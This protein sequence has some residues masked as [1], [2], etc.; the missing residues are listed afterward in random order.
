V[1]RARQQGQAMVEAIV[2]LGVIVFLFLGIFYLG[3]FHDIQAGTIQSARYAAW[4]RTVHSQTKMSDASVQKQARARLFTWNQNAF[5]SSDGLPNGSGWTGQSAVWYDHA[6]NQR[7]VARPDD[8]VVG[9]TSGPL[10]GVAGATV[11]RALDLINGTAVL[12]GGEALPRGGLATSTVAV[13]LANVAQLPAP[14]NKL[15]LTL[16]EQGAVVVDSWDASGPQQ[17]ALRTRSFTVA[18]PITQLNGLLGPVEWALSWI[19]PSFRDLHI[20]Q[21]CPDIVPADR[22]EGSAG[23]PAYRGG[24]ACVR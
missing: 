9:T 24:G 19:E 4:E 8:V 13:R 7:L 10:P 3:K 11:S 14:L 1:K 20:G 16:R 21:V 6:G 23:L 2:I 12:T 18:G 17:T 22:L 5:K 15:D